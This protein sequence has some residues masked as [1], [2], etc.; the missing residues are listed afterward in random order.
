MRPPSAMQ[1]ARPGLATRVL[2]T[3]RKVMIGIAAER[4][5]GGLAG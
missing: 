1:V 4:A 2:Q 5:S 3:K